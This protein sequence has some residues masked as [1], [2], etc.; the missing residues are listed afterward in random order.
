MG[1]G[2]IEFIV[3]FVKLVIEV[4][5]IVPVIKLL[6]D[7]LLLAETLPDCAFETFADT[8]IAG[9][10]EDEIET[11]DDGDIAGDLE[12][13]VETRDDGDCDRDDVTLK[14][15]RAV[16]VAEEHDDGC[17][18]EV[19]VTDIVGLEVPVVETDETVDTVAVIVANGE[20]V[21]HADGTI[22]IEVPKLALIDPLTPLDRLA[23]AMEFDANIDGE[24]LFD[25]N[26][27]L[28][29]LKMEDSVGTAVP[30]VLNVGVADI[31]PPL[32][33]VVAILLIVG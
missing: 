16:L 25:T 4:C 23:G 22:D 33:V 13:E 27:V 5:D 6:A 7:T 2:V 3:V 31:E 29:A 18:V 24:A 20:D 30:L 28:E 17:E 10:L 14:E 15:A 21:A 8:D 26:A 1:V 12:D 11:S 9:D 19:D 32:K